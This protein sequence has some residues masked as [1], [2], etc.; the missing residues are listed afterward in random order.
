[1]VFVPVY[2]CEKQIIRVLGQ[3]TP[4]VLKFFSQ[5][6]IVNN[7]STDRS[8]NVI[9]EYLAEYPEKP[10]ILLRNQQNYGLGGSHKVAF[11]YAL[12]HGF[13]FIAVLHGD[14]QGHIEN[15][16][17]LLEKGYHREYD[18]LLGARFMRS[19]I[20]DGY[21]RFRT[22]GN[23][24]YN[25]MFSLVCRKMIFDLGAGL[26]L[27]ST[28]MLREKFYEKFPDNLM[29]NYCMVMAAADLK[30]KACF[31]PIRWS[32]SDQISNVR[33]LSQALSV[34][35]MLN[36]FFWNRKRFLASEMRES[37]VERYAADIVSYSKGIPS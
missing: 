2:N 11:Q 8:E 21:S 1:M 14:D 28:A 6:I 32:E 23:R 37:P 16:L 3:F 24:V 34:A 17:P 29:F 35:G 5:V 4:E 7:R 19:S 30:H 33:L 20:L 13:D 18:C 27:Y 25:L 9:L 10:I 12:E 36:R 31:F 22:F 15:L 26:N